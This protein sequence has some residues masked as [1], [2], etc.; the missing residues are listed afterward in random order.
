MPTYTQT[1]SD[2]EVAQDAID[3]IE[4]KVEGEYSLGDGYVF[5][6]KLVKRGVV[7]FLSVRFTGAQAIN[8]IPSS[9][10]IKYAKAL[11]LI[12]QWEKDALPDFP[13]LSEL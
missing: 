6:V 3:L 8:R 9:V 1:T 10:I 12:G 11:E 4:S 7:V 13:D 2:Y 5:K